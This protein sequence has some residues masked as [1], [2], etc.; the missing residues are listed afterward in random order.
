M[1]KF[2][3]S[4]SFLFLISMSLSSNM[5]SYANDCSSQTYKK[6]EIECQSNDEDCNKN[7]VE[8]NLNNFDA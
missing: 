8:Q 4:I 7:K 2:I 5:P 3:S 1:N 6:A